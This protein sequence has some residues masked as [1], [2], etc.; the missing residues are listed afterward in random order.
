MSGKDGAARCSGTA[1]SEADVLEAVMPSAEA[2]VAA[3]L[4]LMTGVVE[5][6]ALRAP[7]S[8]HEQSRVMAA[9]VRA[10]LFMLA[11]HEQLSQPLRATL[12]RLSSHWGQ[13]AADGRPSPC[14]CSAAATPRRACD[15]LPMPERL[16]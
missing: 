5:R 1:A 3:T 11:H 15:W 2:L 7:L 14:A 13:L 12:A 16:Q 6:S 8:S 10:N 4:A 9:K